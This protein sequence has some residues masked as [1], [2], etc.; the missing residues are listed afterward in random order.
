MKRKGCSILFV[1]RHGQILL[2]LR[3]DT[4]GLPYAGMWDLPG[5]HV[6]D[7]ESPDQCIVREMNEELGLELD[8]V[9]LFRVYNFDDR[10]EYVYLKPWDP[11]ITTQ[12]M[13]EGQGLRWFSEED[14]RSTELAYGFNRVC[15]DFFLKQKLKL[16]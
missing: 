4:P 8:E 3:D 1:N 14:V 2:F 5:G 13:T 6:E 15:R 12:V 7:G 16:F 10:I 11:D 9:S